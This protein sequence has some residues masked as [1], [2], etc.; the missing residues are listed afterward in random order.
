MEAVS[1][2]NRR[3][4][5]WLEEAVSSERGENPGHTLLVRCILGAGGCAITQQIRTS[6]KMCHY[7]RCLQMGMNPEKVDATLAKRRENDARVA[8]AAR[9]STAQESSPGKSR[10][11]RDSPLKNTN[12]ITGGETG[13]KELPRHL[14]DRRDDWSRNMAHSSRGEPSKARKHGF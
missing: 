3:R 9:Q 7:D 8:A 4:Q 2:M 14:A 12:M 5:R 11:I 6:F 13:L 10:Q 1:Q